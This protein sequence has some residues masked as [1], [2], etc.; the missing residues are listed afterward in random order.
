MQGHTGTGRT[1]HDRTCEAVLRAN[2]PNHGER[3]D[4]QR[5]EIPWVI[6]TLNAGVESDAI[7]AVGQQR[8]TSQKD[9]EEDDWQDEQR[10]VV[11]IRHAANEAAELGA[12]VLNPFQDV[13]TGTRQELSLLHRRPQRLAVQHTHHTSDEHECRNSERN[14]ETMPQSQVRVALHAD[15]SDDLIERA[16]KHAHEKDD[17]HGHNTRQCCRQPQA[18]RSLVGLR[19]I[20][21]AVEEGAKDNLGR[22]G[23]GK[24][25]TNARD[26]EQNNLACRANRRLLECGEHSFLGYETKER[27]YCGHR[28]R[29]DE[30]GAKRPRHLVPQ[31]AKAADVAGTSLMVNDADKHKDG[32]LEQC[33]RQSVDQRRGDGERGSN[34]DGGHDPTQVGNRGVRSELLQVRLLY[35]EHGRHDGCSHTGH[36]EQPIPCRNVVEDGGEANQQVH[37]GL[38]DGRR[39]QEGRHWRGRRHGLR[40]P[41][42]ERELRRLGE[43]RQRD[44][45]SHTGGQARALRPHLRSQ[46]SLKVRGSCCRGGNRYTSQQR[47]TTDEG[48]NQRAL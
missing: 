16:I 29:A 24:E 26:D 19:H 38:D 13:I 18:Y 2:Q 46:D 6:Q 43:G 4:T 11:G 39:V 25:G 33:V 5:Q 44:E 7:D 8:R 41:E 20:A 32:G 48:E 14:V 36:D 15:C 17:R 1:D 42:V 40:K 34:T 22:V 21:R 10:R 9:N 12:Y 28:R 23:E 35:R 3:N 27:R 45:D 37:A 31:H 30:H 47:Q